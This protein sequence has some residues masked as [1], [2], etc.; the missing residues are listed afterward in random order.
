[1]LADGLLYTL[2][3]GGRFMV[4]DASTGKSVYVEMLSLKGDNY[5][6]LVLAGP[7]LY[8]SNNAGET[9]VLKPGREF[10]EVAHNTLEPSYAS[11]VFSG[12]RLYVRGQTNLYC[13]GTK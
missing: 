6:S 8:A 11:L 9:V 7:Y 1:M 4:L 3:K 12:T 5:P 13:I 10:Q 2:Q